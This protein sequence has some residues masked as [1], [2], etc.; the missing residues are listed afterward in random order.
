MV[1]WCRSGV[2]VGEMVVVVFMVGVV[3]VMVVVVEAMVVEHD[4]G[5][6]MRF[7]CLVICVMVKWSDIVRCGVK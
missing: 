4:V 6:D 2:G 5:V 3:M 7:V 1:W